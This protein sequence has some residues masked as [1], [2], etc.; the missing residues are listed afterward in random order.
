MIVSHQAVILATPEAIQQHGYHDNGAQCDQQEN[1]G[2][3]VRCYPVRRWLKGQF[4]TGL[5][6]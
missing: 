6:Q 4:P 2:W 1:Q 5:R 3:L